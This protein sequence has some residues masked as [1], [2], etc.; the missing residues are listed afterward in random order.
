MGTIKDVL[1]RRDGLSENDAINRVNEGKK[2]FQKSINNGEMNFDFCGEFF[3]LEV[4]YLFELI[5]DVKKNNE[6]SL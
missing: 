3:G 2:I 4:D 1:I 6:V 5:E